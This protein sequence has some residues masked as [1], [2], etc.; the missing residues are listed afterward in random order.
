MHEYPLS[1]V[2]HVRMKE[3]YTSM[4]PTFKVPS[5]NIIKKDIF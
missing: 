3:V 4:Q 2:K 1:F 5:R